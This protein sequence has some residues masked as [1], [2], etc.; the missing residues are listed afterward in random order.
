MQATQY[1]AINELLDVLLSRMKSILGEKLVGLYLYGSLVWGD[2]DYEISDIDLLA[3]TTTD[4][5]DRE[6]V[7][8]K[9]MHG[10]IANTY[11]EWDNRIEIQYLS[12]A[13]LKTFRLQTTKMAVISPGEPFHVVEAGKEWLMNWYF[14]RERGV[15]LFGPPPGVIIERISKEEFIQAGLRHMKDWRGWITRTRNSRPY[16][17]YAILTAC[18]A[19]YTYKNGEQVSKKQAAQWAAKE[20]P[21]W[22]SLI[23][24]ALKW[25][26][27]AIYGIGDVD[28]E[29]T[30]P[31]ARRFVE[32]VSDQ[33]PVE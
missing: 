18:R 27:E 30:Y 1:P 28:D 23:Q 7:K 25:R 2:F 16:Q 8:L 29:G 31:E 13:G 4:L 6:L 22:A 26:R 5:N 33:I 19:L 32:F 9:R 3:A 14:V 24:D 12:L 17:G 15:T 21:Q 11:K 10:D 20:L